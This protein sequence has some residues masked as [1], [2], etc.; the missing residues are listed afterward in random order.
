[1]KE[2]TCE[3]S[4]LGAFAYSKG[5]LTF[6]RCGGHVIRLKRAEDN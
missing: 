3:Y 5:E 1:M 2:C 4:T 6:N